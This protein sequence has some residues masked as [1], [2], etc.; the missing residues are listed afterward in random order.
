MADVLAIVLAAA[1]STGSSPVLL[2]VEDCPACTLGLYDDLQMTRTTGTIEPFIEKSLYLGI[3]PA[4]SFDLR[5]LEFSIAGLAQ[6]PRFIISF[7]YEPLPITII[8][9]SLAAPA[10]TSVSTTGTGGVTI[11]WLGCPRSGALMWLGFI[12]LEPVVHRVLEIKRRYPPSSPL[13]NTPVYFLCDPPAY[14]PTRIS[15]GCFILNPTAC[16]ACPC[17]TAVTTTSWSIVKALFR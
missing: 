8:Q 10:D 13:W 15:G 17:P 12:C 3:T 2:Q 11:W 4:D 7:P 16:D 6:D 14:T 5:Y 1:L 9:G